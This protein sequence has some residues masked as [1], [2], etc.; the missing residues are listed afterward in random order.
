MRTPLQNSTSGHCMGRLLPLTGPLDISGLA[1]TVCS[2]P[3]T[4][5]SLGCPSYAQCVLSEFAGEW[6]LP[7]ITTPSRL[8]VPNL[9]VYLSYSRFK[10][11]RALAK[12]DLLVQEQRLLGFL[13]YQVALTKD[14]VE[15]SVKE[16]ESKGFNFS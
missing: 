3:R 4:H 10:L 14:S 1:L 16:S 12:C 9:K 5:A 2:F 13:S 15:S 11:Q 7:G 6:I 8:W